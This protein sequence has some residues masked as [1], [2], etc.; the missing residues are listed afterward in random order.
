MSSTCPSVAKHIFNR[1]K[2]GVMISL[3]LNKNIDL[4]VY[5]EKV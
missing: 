2:A 1:F 3:S 4:Y 5:N